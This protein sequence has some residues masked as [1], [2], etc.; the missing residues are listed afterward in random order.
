M[1]RAMTD[2][3][4]SRLIPQRVTEA[5]HDLRNI[6]G[7]ILGFTELIVEEAGD[8]G[9]AELV[10]EL[11]SLHDAAS[12]ILQQLSHTLTVENLTANPAA[13]AA[14]GRVLQRFSQEAAVAATA[15]HTHCAQ[16]A[17]PLFLEDLTRISAAASRLGTRAP[18]LLTQMF[19][20]VIPANAEAK[21]G[22]PGDRGE[23]TFF[24]KPAATLA[25]APDGE[26]TTFF[27]RAEVRP[28]ATGTI[29]VVDDTESNRALLTRRL[30][31]EGFTVAVAEHGRRALDLLGRHAFDLVLLDI[32]MPEMDGHQVLTTM[33]ADLTLRHIPVIMISGLD[34][35]DTLVR[36]IE[37]GA[38]DYLTKPFDPVLLRARISACLDKKRL[39]DREREHL[40]TIEE[41]RRRADELLH[42][43]LPHSIAVEL[44]ETNAVQPRHHPHVAVL[45]S[46]VVGFTAF[47]DQHPAT[48]VIVHLQAL[49]RAF[50]EIA[51]RH[52]LEKI[53]T[54]GDAFM[55]TAG[56][57]EPVANPAL[58]AVRAGLEM[59]QAARGL[60]CG[61][62]VHVG[63]HTGPVISGVVGQRKYLFDV[64]GDTVNTASRMCGLAGSGDVCV[65][66]HTWRELADDCTGVSAG[67]FPVKGKG[68]LQ[69]FRV[70]TAR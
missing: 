38:E 63:V 26:N 62:E 53:K 10:A 27:T 54:I 66:E 12:E 21:P 64:W 4:T 48:E 25:A 3:F 31:R 8:L 44:K 32:M 9:Q 11:Q 2:P 24:R 58:N 46:D 47:C 6:L 1:P 40:A 51:A 52:G 5:R 37:G 56:L 14:L 22:H 28:P 70:A 36:C 67:T 55:A 7:Q 42:V 23:T 61:W 43:I 68:E 19:E 17:G 33:K 13:S 45:F 39:R 50:E 41:Q 60:S 20:T 69:V 49:V 16:L 29:L 15:F 34:D 65:S 30:S 18:E 35:L 57:I 59:V